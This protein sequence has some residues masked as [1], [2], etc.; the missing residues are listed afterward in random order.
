MKR[1]VV[2][3]A[4]LRCDQGTTPGS[5][6]VLPAGV[7]GTERAAATVSDHVAM[8]NLP[9]LGACRS[10]AN[11]QVAAA[12]AAAMG[13]LT[14][15]PCVPVTPAAWSVEAPGV[16]VGGAPALVEGARCACAWGGTIRVE[17]P[18]GGAVGAG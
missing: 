6:S 15:Q 7:S 5:L 18:G 4:T 9:P 17:S 11:P 10:L 8:K 12:S 2:H 1:L 3:G 13:V 14:P 16:S